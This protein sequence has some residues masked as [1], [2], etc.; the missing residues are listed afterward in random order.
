MHSTHLLLV[1]G[2]RQVSFRSAGRHRHQHLCAASLAPEALQEAVCR[3]DDGL[4]AALAGA[5]DA[6]LLRQQR[7]QRG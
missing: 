1:L 6:A 7:G 3:G 4:G 2:R 5:P